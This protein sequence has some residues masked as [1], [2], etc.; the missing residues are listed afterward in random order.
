VL[1][2]IVITF[3][4]VLLM[5]WAGSM[6][7]GSRKPADLTVR[8]EQISRRQQTQVASYD[9]DLMR[10]Q[11][12]SSVPLLNR[13]LRR[14]SWSKTLQALLTQAGWKLK[15]AKLVLFSAV[16]SLTS[17][18]ISWSLLPSL[19]LAILIGVSSGF[20]PFLFAS[21]KRAQ[22]FSKFQRGFPEAIDLLN[23]AVR[24]GHAFTSGLELISNELADPIATEFRTT[25][26][27][28]NL[29]LPLRDALF[30]LTERVPVPDVRFFVT[31]ML[32]HQETG[33]N[34]A[35]LLENLARVIRERFK[36]LGEVRIRTA[37][38]RLTAV[39][40][41]GLPPLL[42]V[43]LRFLNPDYVM[44]L[45]NDPLGH[46]IL[47]AACVLQVIGAVVLW[48]VVHIEV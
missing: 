39:I 12:L 25:F 34:L 37:Q 42:L 17:F 26:D 48:K 22:R 3:A 47:G 36:I 32:V 23:R 46:K 29:G 44:L 4:A 35:E 45:F 16:L 14:W 41:I 19:A 8:L 21:F 28:H 18:L 24:A 31:A 38:G 6:L 27:E 7:I 11:G 9:D 43:L 13:L 20:S 30:H 5:G 1:F 33:G 40:L 2:V 10:D 15:P